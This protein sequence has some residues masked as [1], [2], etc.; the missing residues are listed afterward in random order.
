MTPADPSPPHEDEDAVERSL[1]QGL[2]QAPLTDAAYARIH[3]TVASEWRVLHPPKTRWSA[4]RWAAMAAGLAAVVIVAVVALRSSQRPETLGVIARIEGDGLVLR[5][6]M[7]PDRKLAVGA[8]LHSPEVFTAGGSV[9]IE[10]K[11]GGTLRVARGT[12]LEV[13]AGGAVAVEEGEAYADLPPGA[14]RA[15]A[16]VVR[17]PFGLVEHLGTQF[18]V[19]VNNDLRIR[20]REGRVRLRRDSETETVAAGTELFVPRTGPT[21]QHAIATHGPEWSWVEALEP[22]YVIENR[23]LIE[24]LQWAARETGRR[25]SFAD[26]HAREVAEQTRLHGSIS[27]LSPGE[28]LET[29][30]TTTSLRY[31]FEDGVVKVSSGG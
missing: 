29:V 27:G 13:V 2:R 6:A 21:T 28:A 18:D 19:A 17:T 24:F 12:R 5:H 1:E 16:F 20:V 9:L 11:E 22:D 26:D 31:E 30:L 14:T 23:A 15:S 25:L 3:A 7:L 4:P 8:V 10:L